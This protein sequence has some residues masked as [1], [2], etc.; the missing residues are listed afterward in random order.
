MKLLKLFANAVIGHHKTGDVQHE[1]CSI[2]H[3]CANFKNQGLSV[4]R[5]VCVFLRAEVGQRMHGVIPN[6]NIPVTT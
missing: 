4:A 1:L 5:S 2:G 6:M 3:S